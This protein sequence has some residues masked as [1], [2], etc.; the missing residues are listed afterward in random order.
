M[1]MY[2][3][4]SKMPGSCVCFPVSCVCPCLLDAW[5]PGGGTHSR[6][7]ISSGDLRCSSRYESSKTWSRRTWT[8]MSS[9]R[10]PSSSRSSSCLKYL[11]AGKKNQ[12]PH[13]PP[14]PSWGG[15][16]YPAADPCLGPSHRIPGPPSAP[17]IRKV[18]QASCPYASS[19]GSACLPTPQY[20]P[21]LV[22]L[23]L[24]YPKTKYTI[25]PPP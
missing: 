21:K 11:G 14:Q 20:L 19:C 13:L 5:V 9:L 22:P 23:A 15:G 2:A 10:S 16:H 7:F 6:F 25:V 12:G 17:L 8:A 24:R 3:P 4:M 18:P 1:C